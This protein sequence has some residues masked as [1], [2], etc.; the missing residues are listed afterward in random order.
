MQ[1]SNCHHELTA[2]QLVDRFFVEGGKWM[3]RKVCWW[4]IPAYDALKNIQQQPTTPPQTQNAVGLLMLLLIGYVG[5]KLLE[6]Y[7]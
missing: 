6:R 1:C 3:V 5:K 7:S 2:D 4:C